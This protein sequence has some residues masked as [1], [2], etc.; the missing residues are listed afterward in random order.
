MHIYYLFHSFPGRGVQAQHTLVLYFH[1][2]STQVEY[3]QG[4]GLTEMGLRE[5]LLLGSLRL[6]AKSTS[7]WLWD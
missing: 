3:C 1:P 5:H 7:L 2:H 6:L 4:C